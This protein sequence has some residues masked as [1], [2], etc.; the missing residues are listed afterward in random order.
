METQ[1]SGPSHPSTGQQAVTAV[2]VKLPV[3]WTAQPS[4]WFAQAESQFALRGI[5][6]DNTKFHH[7]VAALDQGTAERVLDILE[8]PPDTDKY[9]AIKARLTQAFGLSARQRAAKLLHL[10]GLGDRK[11]SAL[12]DEMLALA[13]GHRT[14][15]LF[16]QLFLEQLP[17]DIRMMLSDQDFQDP[18]K[19]AEAA[20]KLW[21]AR[22]Q[23][24]TVSAVT[25]PG[26]AQ[27]DIMDGTNADMV[28]SS[29]RGTGKQAAPTHKDTTGW[30]F[31]HARWGDKARK[32]KAP[33]S[34]PG[35][36]QA[37]RR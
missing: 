27:G 5:S 20:D 31:F 18:R 17:D 12:M 37:G 21:L 28:V 15:F 29:V 4:I 35:N 13:Q 30:C 23:R 36:G 9:L 10:G 22:G 25:M 19:L 2:T 3:F 6:A 24:S 14:C 7:V 32:C 33:C 1:Q 11:P 26:H 16:E 8:F 34:F